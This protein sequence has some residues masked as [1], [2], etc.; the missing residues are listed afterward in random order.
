MSNDRWQHRPTPVVAPNSGRQPPW[1]MPTT[2]VLAARCYVAEEFLLEGT[3]RGHRIVSEPGASAHGRWDIEPFAEADYRTRILV[4]RPER[5]KD[6]NGTVVVNWQNVSSGFERGTAE[7][8]EVFTG[9]AWVGVSAQAMGIHGAIDMK[10]GS[11]VPLVDHDPERYSTLHHPGDQASFD[12]FSDAGRVVG[13]NRSGAVDPMAGLAVHRL[14]A[15]GGSQ[16][17]MR[18]VTYLNAFQQDAA[19]FDAFLLSVWEGVAPL[20]EQGAMPT[21]VRTVIRT[22]LTNPVIVVNSEF[23]ASHLARLP[24]EDSDRVRIWEVAGAAHAVGR[25]RGDGPDARGR[26]LN[27]LSLRPIQD[28]ALR[29]VHRWLTEDTAPQQQPRIAR[30]DGTPPRLRRDE[31]GN[32]VGGIRLPELAAPTHEYHGVAF[33]TGRLALY[34]SAQPLDD[35][36]VRRLYPTRLVYAQRWHD[37]VDHLVGTGALRAEDAPAMKARVD[38]VTLPV[39]DPTPA[40]VSSVETLYPG[41]HKGDRT[42]PHTRANEPSVKGGS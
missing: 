25:D 39:G 33:G 14:I 23:E 36:V 9:Y 37:A 40:A 2:D 22:D 7:G 31:Y 20:P 26:T 3:A 34:G 13:P 38:K 41:A 10:Y 15:T 17:A 32:A 27:P 4:V 12:I 18:L 11:G 6:F 35:E 8:D 42:P 29:A 5:T 16:S 28:S 1:C 24:I 30:N 21:G 19:V